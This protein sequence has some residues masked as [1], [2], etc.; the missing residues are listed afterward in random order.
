MQWEATEYLSATDSI[1]IFKF[2]FSVSVI[3]TG[4]ISLQ[5]TK[6]FIINYFFGAGGG[7]GHCVCDWKVTIRSSYASLGKVPVKENGKF[8]SWSLKSKEHPSQLPPNKQFFALCVLPLHLDFYS[9]AIDFLFI[10]FLSSHLLSSHSLSSH[11]LSSPSISS[12]LLYSQ[13][14]TCMLN[15]RNKISPI[16]AKYICMHRECSM[17]CQCSH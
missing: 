15:I 13:P 3:G 2:C 7:N 1:F 4:E 9:S 14:F 5:G 8:P 16:I 11:S 17:E 12:H 10:Q 6:F